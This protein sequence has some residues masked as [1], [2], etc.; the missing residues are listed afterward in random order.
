MPKGKR[1][2]KRGLQCPFRDEYQHNLEFDHVN[3]QS[4]SQKW[5]S[6]PRDF[7]G[8]GHKLGKQPISSTS[9]SRNPYESNH[10]KVARAAEERLVSS[11]NRAVKRETRSSLVESKASKRKSNNVNDIVDLVSPTQFEKKAKTNIKKETDT[12]ILCDSSDDDNEILIPEDKYRIRPKLPLRTEDSSFVIDDKKEALK[13]RPDVSNHNDK[14]AIHWRGHYGQNDHLQKAL[15]ASSRMAV[16][17]EQNNEYEESLRQD[18]MKE[19]QR[20]EEMEL[21]RAMQESERLFE[22][23]QKNN[24][25]IQRIEAQAELKPEPKEGVPNVATIAFRLPTRCTKSRLNRRFC[26]QDNV[27]QLMLFLKSCEELRC[28]ESWKLYQVVHGHK[29][30]SV[31]QTIDDLG[32]YPRGILIVKDLDT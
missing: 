2:C 31:N 1:L 5:A 9:T 17:K 32:L 19:R 25:E 13:D 30:V 14:F 7:I 22:E 20:R 8:V 24:L 16:I 18:T 26:C 12:I 3:D 21:Q 27:T 23:K 10:K 29:E 4:A 15:E 6:Q 28:I 11:I